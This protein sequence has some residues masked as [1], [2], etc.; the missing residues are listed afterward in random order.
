MSFSPCLSAI[1]ARTSRRAADA[2][3]VSFFA[4]APALAAEFRDPKNVFVI[5]Y[6]ETVWSLDTDA[7]GD[8]G[9]E[10]QDA[11]CKGSFA[12]CSLSKQR[13]P[14]RS[15]E[16]IM[17]SFDAE[18][19]AREQLAAFAA[20]KAELEDAVAG[21]VRWDKSADVMPELVQPYARVQIGGR[22]VLQA[23]YRMSMAGSLAR[24][25]SYMTATASHSIAMV[26]HAAEADIETWRPRFE[27]LMAAFRPAPSV[28]S[29]R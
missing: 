15:A 28:G 13:S 3:C 10:C 4:A 6:D 22:P 8:F 17:Q 11:A 14:H 16:H 1:L 29:V 18:G 9:V 27:A 20:Q 23:E 12:G 5:T 21:T 7:S 2:L 19:I 26:C 24:Y 25:V